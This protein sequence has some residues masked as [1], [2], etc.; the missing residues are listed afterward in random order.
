M[1]KIIHCADVHLGSKMEAKLP[2]I[3]VDE[4]REEVRHTFHRMVEYAKKEGVRVLLLAGDVFDSD[5]P[6]KRDKQFFYDVV[7]QNPEI[8]FLYL[9][10]NHD[11][12]ESY[13]EE[14]IDNLKCFT[15]SWT[16]YDYGDAYIAGIEI[17]R[18]N[19][20][21]LYSTLQ[22]DK[23]KRN[24]VT[25]HGQIGSASGVDKVNLN[26]L[27]DKHIDYLA[28]GHIHSY[29]ENKLDD[30]GRYAYSGCLEGRGFDECGQKGFVL[31]EIDKEISSRFIPFAK[32]TIWEKQVDISSTR[33]YYAAYQRIK[34]EIKLCADDLYRILLT[35]EVDY[36]H[37]TLAADVAGL[38]GSEC[39]FASVKDKTLQ[40]LDPRAYEGDISLRGEFIREVMRNPEWD[41]ERKSRIITLGLKALSDREVE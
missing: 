10:G 24:I 14:D 26:K 18:E 2:K 22:L 25:L 9:R 23:E 4:R 5:R 12:E 30:R 21:S 3:K 17:S 36:E 8:D 34:E 28:L 1:L 32:R 20:L 41:D 38:L 16:G 19:A 29:E 35:G 6:L 7:K 27:A 37:D 33:N 15:D 31:L 40:K 11:G 13:T 39:Y